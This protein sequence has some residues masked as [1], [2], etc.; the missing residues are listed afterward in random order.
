MPHA[1]YYIEPEYASYVELPHEDHE[2]EEWSRKLIGKKLGDKT[3][4]TT[5]AMSDLP[6]ERRIVKYGHSITME[7]FP[8]RINIYLAEDETTPR[9]YRSQNAS[10]RPRNHRGCGAPDPGLDQQAD[11]ED[12]WRRKQCDY[13]RHVRPAREHPDHPRGAIRDHG[14]PGEQVECPP[15]EGWDAFYLTRLL[16]ICKHLVHDTAIP[17]SHIPLPDPAPPKATPSTNHAKRGA[18][19]AGSN[20]TSTAQHNTSLTSPHDLTASSKPDTKMFKKDISPGSKSKV[21]SSIQRALR[22]QLCTIYPLL[23][24]Y[25]DEV[26][27]KKE[28]LDAMKIPERVTLYLINGEPVFF[29][30]MTD[31]LLPHLKLVHRFPQAFPRIRI[32]RGAI[33]FVLSGA[34]LM[35]P[36]V[37]SDGGRL[38]GDDDEEWGAGGEH[39]EKGAPVVIA[40]EGK[41]EACAVGLLTVGTKEVEEVGKGPVVEDAHFLGDGLWRLNTE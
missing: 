1:V 23:T 14:L 33:R 19:I 5:F 27:P 13:V 29:Q 11:G 9:N 32:D 35:A 26:V 16:C 2:V 30:H 4:E 10:R 15:C 3:D 41:E 40:A 39:L 22:T 31:P 34:T 37:T 21:K 20:Q 6:P 7:D 28:Q 36:G 25:I 24:P 18:T 8:D 17:L 12:H 38:P